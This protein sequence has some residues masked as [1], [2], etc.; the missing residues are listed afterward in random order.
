ML[1]ILKYLKPY[2]PLILIAIALLFV[3]ANADLALPDYL[4]KIVNNGIQQGGVEN[5]VPKAIRQSEMNKLVLF[6]SPEDQRLVLGDYTLVDKNSASYGDYL[7]LYPVLASEPVYVLKSVNQAEISRLDPIM[8]KA[9]L[10]VSSIEQA[11]ANPAK[12][13]SMGQSLGFDLSKI[14]PG[15]DVFAMLSKLPP[16]T[17]AK[18]SEVINQKFSALG[19][20]MIVQMAVGAIRAENTALGVD[21]NKV[22]TNY[23]LYTGALMLLLTLLS[24]TCTIAVG[25]LS[26]RT[27]AGLARDLR[28]NVFQRV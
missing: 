16:A 5:A 6:M 7:K 28:R 12:A 2:V 27:A 19:A 25:Y 1:R 20:S 21:T 14:P 11:L 23:I 3:Q 4:S 17:L 9:F 26:A 15:T 18:I 8:G 22:Q 13:Q 10:V 24:I